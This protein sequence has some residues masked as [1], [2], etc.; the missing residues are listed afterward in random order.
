MVRR[1]AA[2]NQRNQR[3]SPSAGGRDKPATPTSEAE[4]GRKRGHQGA[5]Q[6][7]PKGRGR[8]PKDSFKPGVRRRGAKIAEHVARWV[9][10]GHPW[11]FRDALLRPLEGLAPGAIIAVADPDGNHLGYALFEP[12]GAVALRMLAR[13]LDFDWTAEVMLERLRAAMA[14]RDRYVEPSFAGASRLLH[15]DGDGFP[16]VAVDRYGE[17]LLVYKYAGAADSYLDQLVPLLEQELAPAGIYLQDRTRAVA[18]E[19]SSKRPPAKLLTGKIAPPE[20]EVEEDGLRFLVD[21]TAPVSPGLFLDLREG[22]RLLERVA[23]GKRVLNL[24]SFTGA[25]ALR[26]VRAGASDVTN[27]D[28]AARSHARTRQNLAA[29]GMDPEA[30]E[31]LAGD[32]FKHLERFRQRDRV[33]DLVVVD[34]PPFSTVKGSMFSALEHWNQLAEA[35]AH[36]VAPAGEVLAVAN[37]ASL[38]EEEFLGAIGEGSLMAGRSARVIA[39]VGLPPDFPVL[40]AFPEG[41]YLKVKLLSLA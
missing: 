27:V 29:S 19:D 41:K 30:C 35:V 26:A 8:K 21:V 33:F 38:T 28:A 31:A 37:A 24:F 6:G 36:V 40:A 1:M 32:V 11:I 16:G 9:R 17:Y 5:R 10:A 14:H 2:A 34:P 15:A 7:A 12:E 20:F 22:R 18:A 4:A 39:E 25:L 13:E 23:N 3:K